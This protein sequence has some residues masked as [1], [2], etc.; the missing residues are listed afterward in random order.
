MKETELLEMK[1]NVEKIY[2]LIQKKINAFEKNKKTFEIDR[3]L[4]EKRAKAAVVI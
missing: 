3:G 4:L 1:S 2:K